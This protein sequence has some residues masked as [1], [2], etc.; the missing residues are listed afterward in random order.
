MK[1]LD[2][3][4]PLINQIQHQEIVEAMLQGII[5][6]E[7]SL[8]NDKKRLDNILINR[9]FN[10]IK[11]F[12]LVI[13]NIPDIMCSGSITPEADFHGNQLV[14]LNKL[15]LDYDS[16]TISSFYSD[17]KGYITFV[18][19]HEPN[20]FT[21][22]FIDSFNSLDDSAISHAFVR[23]IFQFL[24]N[25]YLSPAWWD[26]LSNEEKSN[27]MDRATDVI[28]HPERIQKSLLDDNQRVVKWKIIR[29]I[30]HY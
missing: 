27:L 3:G 23:L 20:M 10:K 5:S 19:E 14:D 6:G 16:V 11:Y 26:E 7:R 17:G 21:T 29:R 8:I 24:D 22:K 2:K 18:W 4:Y 9:Q 12:I 25:I 30:A 15:N 1:N 13:D 28:Y